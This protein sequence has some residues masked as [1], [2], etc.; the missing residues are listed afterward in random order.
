MYEIWSLERDEW[1]EMNYYRK[2]KLHTQIKRAI[3]I[4]KKLQDKSYVVKYGNPKPLFIKGIHH[5]YR[6]D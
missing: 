1:G 5:D 3:N 4:C 6:K 2:G